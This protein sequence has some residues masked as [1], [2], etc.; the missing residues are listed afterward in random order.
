MGAWPPASDEQRTR[1]TSASNEM[2]MNTTLC[3]LRC[4]HVHYGVFAIKLSKE[5]RESSDDIRSQRFLKRKIPRS[6]SCS[7]L[8][9]AAASEACKACEPCA[10]HG[11]SDACEPCTAREAGDACALLSCSKC[12]E[13]IAH[14]AGKAV[15]EWQ[16]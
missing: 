5:C 14:C 1:A 7:L 16:S 2:L 4:K 9:L 6:F 11:A 10:A 8:I 12:T 13:K 15:F 3:N